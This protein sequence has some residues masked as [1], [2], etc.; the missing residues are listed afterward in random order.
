MKNELEILNTTEKNT[1]NIE[2]NR[3]ISRVIS[4]RC[5]LVFMIG[6]IMLF[7]YAPEDYKFSL[8]LTL[9][10]L[11]VY[12][13]S[14]TIYI[15]VKKFRA[16]L[17]VVVMYM[18]AVILIILKYQQGPEGYE[19]LVLLI[20]VI[21]YSAAYGNKVNTLKLGIFSSILYTLTY[22][23]SNEYIF[24]MLNLIRLL[25][26]NVFIFTC[27]FGIININKEL[28]KFNELHKKEF[29]LAR[30][31]RLTGLYNRHSLEQRI[32]E[33]A[34]YS[35]YTGKPLNILIFDLDNFKGFNDTYGHT[36]GDKLLILFSGIIKQNIRKTDTAFRYGGEEF[37]ILIR[38]LDLHSAKVIGERIRSQL[39]KQRMYVG[40]GD[41][42]ERVTASCGIAQYPLHSNDI[43]K[44][45]EYADNALYEA[46]NAGKNKVV[47]FEEKS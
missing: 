9:P 32:N 30:T 45:I 44:V 5:L 31:D 6:L 13:L 27:A 16:C 47:V 35:E 33:D 3:R 36:W 21:G 39:E 19:I 38:E 28:V 20:F 42:K 10:V 4:A 46:K 34:I 22:V 17:P 1:V 25:A 11:A 40:F 14:I 2:R 43:Y 12:N 41:E 7:E 24:S 8:W 29:A 37:L 26:H 15:I 18:D 23:L